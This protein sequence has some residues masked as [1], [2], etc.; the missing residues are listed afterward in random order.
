MT[1]SGATSDDKVGIMPTLFSGY[2]NP[3]VSPVTELASWPL[4]VFSPI[5]YH[6]SLPL[7]VHLLKWTELN[8]EKIYLKL[9]HTLTIQQQTL[10]EHFNTTEHILAHIAC[11]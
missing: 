3:P 4:S 7:D 6:A 11:F 5:P 9:R 1:T 2:D 10:F 8:F